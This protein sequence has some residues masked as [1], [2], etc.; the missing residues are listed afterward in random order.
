MKSWM[1][2]SPFSLGFASTYLHG[3]NKWTWAGDDCAHH[4]RG[5]YGLWYFKANLSVKIV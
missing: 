3:E 2:I 1:E 4:P 5:S